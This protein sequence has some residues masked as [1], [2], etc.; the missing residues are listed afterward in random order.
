MAEVRLA[1]PRAIV[2]AENFMMIL[3]LVEEEG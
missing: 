1:R 3:I 2:E